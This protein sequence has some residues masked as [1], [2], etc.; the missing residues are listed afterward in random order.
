MANGNRNSGSAAA[1]RER[2]ATL[3][4]VLEHP[5]LAEAASALGVHRNTLA[6]RLRRIEAIAGWRVAEPEL[7]L[8][9]AIAVRLVQ[10][11]QD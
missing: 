8:P 9:L 1:R 4:A 10:S 5:G 2:L 11:E 7:R 3:A 6:Y